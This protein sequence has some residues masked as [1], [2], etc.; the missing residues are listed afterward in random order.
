MSAA[1][2]AAATSDGSTESV[3]PVG[4]WVAGISVAE[5]VEGI[6]DGTVTA[7]VGDEMAGVVGKGS[8]AP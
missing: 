3:G 6:G 1:G 5:G 7:S 2:V 4:G 8:P